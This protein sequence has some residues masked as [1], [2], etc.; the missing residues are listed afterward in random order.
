M[1][2]CFHFCCTFQQP[3]EKQTYRLSMKFSAQ[4]PYTAP[5]VRFETTCFHPNVDS[6]GN[7]CLDILKVNAKERIT[8]FILFICLVM[9][10]QIK[11]ETKQTNKNQL[12]NGHSNGNI[13]LI[14]LT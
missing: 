10:L 11:Q 13:V 2:S 8:L 3:Y 6:N 1:F 12:A 9:F 5:T 4:Y 7:I 14:F